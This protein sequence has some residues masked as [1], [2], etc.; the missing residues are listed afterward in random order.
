[1]ALRTYLPL[2]RVIARRVCIYINDHQEKL[3]KSIGEEHVGKLL[4]ANAACAIL[5]S[6]LD[7]IIP[8]PS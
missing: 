5:V 2:L 3:E 1:M 6:A 7:T 8:N 4:A